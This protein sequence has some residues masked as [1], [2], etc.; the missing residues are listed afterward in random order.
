MIALSFRVAL[1]REVRKLLRVVRIAEDAECGREDRH[2][3]ARDLRPEMGLLTLRK[4]M[5]LFANL[6]PATVLPAM[7]KASSL[8]EVG[9]GDNIPKSLTYSNSGFKVCYC[10]A[11][12]I[13]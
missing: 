3:V 1:A 13:T 6:R 7:A 4:E 11:A 12:A 5:D 8:S 2:G 9:S 10:S